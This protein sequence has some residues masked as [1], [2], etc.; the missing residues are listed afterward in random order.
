MADA[1]INDTVAMM[2]VAVGIIL[3]T[4]SPFAERR[5]GDE[6]ALS[7]L[8]GGYALF[9]TAAFLLHIS[10][11]AIERHWLGLELV[12]ETLVG[13][14]FVAYVFYA[15]GAR[16]DFA[17]DLNF[18]TGKHCVPKLVI[19]RPHNAAPHNK[20]SIRTRLEVKARAFPT[21]CDLR[22]GVSASG[23]AYYGF[24]WE[25][26]KPQV[27][28]YLFISC[29]KRGNECVPLASVNGTCLITDGPVKA[30]VEHAISYSGDTVIVRST[31]S[32]AVGASGGS[33]GASAFGVGVSFGLP[34]NSKEFREEMGTFVWRCIPG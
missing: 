20:R 25:T 17:E 6:G 19:G 28:P 5:A 30:Q 16:L 29:V 21:D 23:R 31:V 7:V 9:L 8:A 3:W 32:A 13:W 26:G 11:Q 14:G 12:P 10:R 2:C 1:A 22:V 34:A 4:L 27:S 15:Y 24:H 18:P 33:A